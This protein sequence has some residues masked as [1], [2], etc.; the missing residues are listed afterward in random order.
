M[1]IHYVDH[2]QQKIAGTG[3]DSRYRS[4][5]QIARS[6]SLDHTPHGSA[7]Q[8]RARARA[9]RIAD[10]KSEARSRLGQLTDETLRRVAVYVAGGLVTGGVVL[11]ASDVGCERHTW[12]GWLLIGVP[13]IWLSFLGLAALTFVALRVVVWGLRWSLWFTARLSAHARVGVPACLVALAGTLVVLVGPS[14]I[15][16]AIA[17]LVVF[18]FPCAVVIGVG[19]WL[20]VL[21]RRHWHDARWRWQRHAAH[22]LLALVAAAAILSLGARD[23]LAAQAMV[24][25]LFPVAVWLGVRAWRAM[26]RCSLIAVRALTDIVVPLMLGLTLV[27]LV[28]LGDAL[29]TPSAGGANVREALRLAGMYANQPQWWWIGLYVLA[30]GASVLFARLYP[31]PDRLP[32]EATFSLLSRD[33]NRAYPTVRAAVSHHHRPTTSRGVLNPSRASSTTALLMRWA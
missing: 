20:A 13:L 29:R 21:T 24:G 22:V 26:N 23:T 19:A 33:D 11:A 30:A 32:V 15:R 10:A 7:D 4:F 12:W 14:A 28:W 3:P 17:A 27:A 1:P 6:Q 31:Q 9:R 8:A 18:A 16:H 2:F 25:L 5:A